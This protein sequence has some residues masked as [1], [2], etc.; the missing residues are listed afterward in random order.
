MN[1]VTTRFG[2]VQATEADLIRIPDGLIGFR[3]FTQYVLLPDSGAAGLS[4]L[5][6][7]TAP[8]LAFGLVP[9]PPSAGDYRVDLRPGDRA[10]L[11]LDEGREAL[12][13]V[14]L[15]RGEGGGLT[16]NLQGKDGRSTPVVNGLTMNAEAAGTVATGQQQ[17]VN[18]TKLNV[19]EQ[20][21]RLMVQKVSDGPLVLTNGPN[22]LSKSRLPPKGGA[23]PTLTHYEHFVNCFSCRPPPRPPLLVFPRRRPHNPHR[24]H[25]QPHA[26]LFAPRRLC[27]AHAPRVARAQDHA[28]ARDEG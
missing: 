4:W 18:L 17:T 8:E 6:S 9:P 11:E 28:P 13:Y 7:T 1:I 3:S 14:I 15:N 10:A 5:Q 19:V 22:G 21:K 20:N 26:P 12:V 24:P 16:V 2:L 27:A 25:V 23:R